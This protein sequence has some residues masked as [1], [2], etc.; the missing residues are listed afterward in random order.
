MQDKTPAPPPA[1]TVTWSD[2]YGVRDVRNALATMPAAEIDRLPFGVIKVDRKGTILLYNATEGRLA[3]FD[4][5]S[6]VG[7][8]FFRDIAPCTNRPEFLGRFL[9]GVKAGRFDVT[10]RYV[11]RLR[12]VP[13]A[14]TVNLRS[15]YFDE[16]VWILVDWTPEEDWRDP[17]PPPPG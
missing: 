5:A 16:A 14:V 1:P 3:G 11:F 9:Q 10:F 15:S 7:R 6:V 4:P 12:G 17:S 2:T 13:I 8:N